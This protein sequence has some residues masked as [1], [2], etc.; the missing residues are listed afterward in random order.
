MGQDLRL[1][2]ESLG[3]GFQLYYSLKKFRT[4]DPI[5][6]KGEFGQ[7]FTPYL[8]RVNGDI[9]LDGTGWWAFMASGAQGMFSS[10]HYSIQDQIPSEFP[11]WQQEFIAD[12]LK[13]IAYEAG[14]SDPVESS[15]TD[16]YL[17]APES[18]F[19]LGVTRTW[20]QPDKDVLLHSIVNIN[21][22][23]ITTGYSEGETA[24]SGWFHNVAGTIPGNNKNINP[25]LLWEREGLHDVFFL[26]IADALKES[27]KYP[28]NSLGFRKGPSEI[29]LT[30][31]DMAIG[32]GLAGIYKVTGI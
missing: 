26:Q 30:A 11:V 19:G 22:K 8:L 2:K 24:D 29:R 10:G 18:I 21:G 15:G 9:Q 27:H 17:V 14:V 5:E 25:E 4:D 1:I 28:R 31:K 7:T 32:L 20:S 23:Y 3:Y 6:M 16:K 13:R 12:S